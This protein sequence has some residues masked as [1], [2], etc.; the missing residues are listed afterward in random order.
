MLNADFWWTF[1]L[2]VRVD[3]NIFEVNMTNYSQN[4]SKIVLAST[5]DTITKKDFIVQH[6][7]TWII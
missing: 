2:L 6:V 3:A 1:S 5:G 7:Y 4:I